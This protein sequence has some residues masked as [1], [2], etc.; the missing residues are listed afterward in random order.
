MK[1]NLDATL[2][3]GVSHH[4]SEDQLENAPHHIKKLLSIEGIR[5][6]YQVSDFISISRH[7]QYDWRTILP[8]VAHLF[9]DS[10]VDIE[11]MV[12]SFSADTDSE[13]TGVHVYVQTVKGIP[14]QIKLMTL[15]QEKRYPLP[16]RFMDAAQKVQKSVDNLL[17]ARQ[18]EE[19]GV[20]YGSFD[21]IGR[22]V[23]EE[24]DAVYDQQ[25]L[26]QLV[27]QALAGQD[28]SE[29]T[30]SSEQ[31]N[32]LLSD[33]DWKKRFAALEQLKLTEDDLPVLQKA[34]ND[35]QVAIRRLA[36]AYLGELGSSLGSDKVLPLLIKALE[37]ESPIVR[38][39]AGDAL[40]DLGDI[41]AQEAMIDAL[42]DEHKI[43]RWRAARFMYEVG[44]ERAI[45]A[46]RRALNDPEFEISLQAK[47]AL[48]RIEKGTKAEGTVWQQIARHTNRM[49]EK[50]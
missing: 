8:Q 1:L 42:S 18:W 28:A 20:R 19:Y 30:I 50:E 48:E 39:T 34:L 12:Q 6:V 46:L 13:L 47:L 11:G 5:S 49:K 35:P 44:D 29:E 38:R 33:P 7:P 24:I 45:P 17:T 32:T 21:E 23:A 27:Q 2:P 37:D 25:R 26:N 15:S 9:G 14:M 41:R 16:E 3:E 31:V 43:V 22:Q 36:T 10:D 4:F 40:S